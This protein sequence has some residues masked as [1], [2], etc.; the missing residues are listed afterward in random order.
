M[1]NIVVW[2][3]IGILICLA[4]YVVYLMYRDE[5][6]EIKKLLCLK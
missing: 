3:I 2:I 4:G 5:W 6:E 1:N